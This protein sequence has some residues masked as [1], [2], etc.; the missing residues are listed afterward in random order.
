MTRIEYN[1]YF[2]Y[3]DWNSQSPNS[4]TTSTPT[5]LKSWVRHDNHQKN[6]DHHPPC[7]YPPPH[8]PPPNNPTHHKLKL[9]ERARI[10]GHL[11]N[12][13]YIN[14]KIT[15]LGPTL[16]PKITHQGQNAFKMTPKSEKA[17]CQ[18]KILQKK[19]YLSMR[20]KPQKLFRPH[21]NSKHSL[22]KPN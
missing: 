12:R 19:S 13:P 8:H 20:V 4:T 3:H 17:K 2:Y 15:K 6:T 7:H 9:Q 21:I 22:I 16:A 10:E 11:E 14:P 5:Q 1:I 18:K